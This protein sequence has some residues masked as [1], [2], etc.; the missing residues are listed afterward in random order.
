MNPTI[1]RILVSALVLATAVSAA[2]E[3][4]TEARPAW[5]LHNLTRSPDRREGEAVVI[6]DPTSPRHAFV[7][8]VG[9][10]R[11]EERLLAY[12]T[13]DGG[14]TWVATSLSA[15]IDGGLGGGNPALAADGR[16]NLFL[17]YLT[18]EKSEPT[19]TK[20]LHSRDHGETWKEIWSK[21][22]AFLDQPNLTV[23]TPD[24]KG[25]SA[26][27]LV[28]G[29]SDGVRAF[30]A[31]L[32]DDGMISAM[33]EIP[34]KLEGK[35]VTG[36]V[37]GGEIIDNQ[38]KV[39]AQGRDAAW[40]ICQRCVIGADKQ[41]RPEKLRLFRL[42]KAAEQWSAAAPVE[43]MSLGQQAAFSHSQ[44]LKTGER[45]LI[46]SP[47][48]DAL[49]LLL[50]D[51]GGK[52]W[53][54]PEDL[55]PAPVLYLA[56]TIEESRA[57]LWASYL[58]VEASPQPALKQHVLRHDLKSG[59]T[60]TFGP[61]EPA[62]RPVP[63]TVPLN[64]A[65]GDYAGISAASGK[66]IATFSSNCPEIAGVRNPMETSDA[67][68]AIFDSGGNESQGEY[69]VRNTDYRLKTGSQPK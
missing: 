10:P 12:R 64:R 37:Q 15:N 55:L 43:I 40:L 23:S 5:T 58:T 49:V 34:L 9:A 16:G 1:T 31:D 18:H 27:W 22:G 52:S 25:Q 68:V 45:L 36:D 56:A 17:A 6:I 38:V 30:S 44:L 29:G 19:S 54:K 11:V 50:S 20:I 39:A 32:S 14:Q 13:G 69:D 42:S 65:F 48:N 24:A 2:A 21:R 67:G 8:L 47:Q 3:P 51:D 26:L 46:V 59:K 41:A 60:D 66:V 7:A 62:V 35:R 57:L 63:T 53:G 28:G 61:L 4:A 33:Q